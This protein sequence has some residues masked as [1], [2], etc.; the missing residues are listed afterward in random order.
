MNVSFMNSSG[1]TS[2]GG[3]EKWMIAIGKALR[4]NGHNVSFTGRK[5]SFFLS[6]CERLKFP[7]FHLNISIDF[8]PRVIRKLHQFYS[9]NETEMIIAE[10]NKDIRAVGIAIQFNG[11]IK[12]VAR[13]GLPSI[14]NNWRYK[15]LF[16]NILDGLIVTTNTIQQ[17]YQSYKWMENIPTVVIP[18]GISKIELPDKVDPLSELPEGNPTV[19]IIGKLQKKKQ[20]DIFLEIAANLKKK[21]E[22][23]NFLIVGDGPER[24]NIQDYANNLGILDDVYMVGYQ[25]I[26]LPYYLNSDVILLTSESEGIPQVILEAMML[27]KTVAAFD[28]GGVSELIDNNVNGILVP[29]NDI[30]KMTEEVSMLLMD[31]DYSVELGKKARKKIIEKYSFEEMYKRTEEFLLKIANQ[32]E[33]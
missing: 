17:V 22:K 16:P 13:T 29:P 25:K 32:K 19:S 11:D 24:I 33:K 26:L 27:G 23:I 9:E 30:F 2:N 15:I 8:D 12:L 3:S 20:H 18:N 14:K 28:V 1:T 7:T 4:N 6:E 31:P 21:F 5:D 10:R